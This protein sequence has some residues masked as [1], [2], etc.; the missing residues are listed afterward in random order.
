M[1]VIAGE[2]NYLHSIIALLN[3]MCF[4]VNALLVNAPCGIATYPGFK[5]RHQIW[6]EGACM[7]RFMY[8]E[9]RAHRGGVAA[10]FCLKGGLFLLPLL[11]VQKKF[12]VISMLLLVHK[13]LQRKCDRQKFVLTVAPH[14]DTGSLFRK[15]PLVMHVLA[16]ACTATAECA[17]NSLWPKII[18]A[19]I[20]LLYLS[21]PSYLKAILILAHA[22]PRS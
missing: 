18:P 5:P 3:K 12:Q 21:P 19:M 2:H 1:M 6:G 20:P 11:Q 7:T 13:T 8:T 16:C 4:L 15:L 9:V 22:S 14:M 17:I 10:C